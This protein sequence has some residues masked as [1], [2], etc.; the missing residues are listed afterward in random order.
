[1]TR[2]RLEAIQHLNEEFNKSF[3]QQKELIT[4]FSVDY[5][6]NQ[7]YAWVFVIDK[8]RMIWKYNFETGNIQK[9]IGFPEESEAE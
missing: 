1:M 8:E 7:F 3:G 6:R 4:D 5:Q 2:D 9:F